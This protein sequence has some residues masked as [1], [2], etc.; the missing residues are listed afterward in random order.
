M[1]TAILGTIALAAL[2]F[3]RFATASTIQYLSN[4]FAEV[5]T[6]VAYVEPWEINESGQVT[7]RAQVDSVV[8]PFV[9]GPNGANLMLI[10]LAPPDDLGNAFG[11]NDLGQVSGSSATGR[12]VA[13]PFFTAPNDDVAQYFRFHGYASDINNRGQVVGT[14]IRGPHDPPNAPAGLFDA[15]VPTFG[16][17]YGFQAMARALGAEVRKTGL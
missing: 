11:I 12:T 4:S 7:G 6:E 13:R 15:G 10:S 2:S 16:I 9:T 17:C 8:V 3:G 14:A 1:K 5:G